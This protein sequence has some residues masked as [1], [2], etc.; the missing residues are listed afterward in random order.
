VVWCELGISKCFLT[1]DIGDELAGW[2]GYYDL[3]M[4]GWIDDIVRIMRE[5][6]SHCLAIVKPF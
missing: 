3:R 2:C 5:R 1:L 4:R 6:E